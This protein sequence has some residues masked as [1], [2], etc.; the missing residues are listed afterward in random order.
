MDNFASLDTPGDP[1]GV[2]VVELSGMKPKSADPVTVN[3]QSNSL[4]NLVSKDIRHLGQVGAEYKKIG[5]IKVMSYDN[6]FYSH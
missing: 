2:K 6:I 3:M 5:I 4:T 1:G